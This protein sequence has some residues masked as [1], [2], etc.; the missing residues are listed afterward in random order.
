[1]PTAHLGSFANLLISNRSSLSFLKLGIEGAIAQNSQQDDPSTE[2]FIHSYTQDLGSTLD[3][4][5]RPISSTTST[6]ESILNDGSAALLHTGYL[7][8]IGF[9]FSSSFGKRF[10][11]QLF[12]LDHL[13]HLVLESCPQSQALFD[14][15]NC[16]DPERRPWHPKLKKLQLRFEQATSS[17]MTQ[18]KRFLFRFTGLESLQVLLE[19][20]VN[21]IESGCIIHHGHSLRTLVWDHRTRPVQ[22][23]NEQSHD[24]S[25]SHQTLFLQG[26]CDGC[27]ELR[28][29]GVVISCSSRSGEY[30]VSIYYDTNWL[31]LRSARASTIL[32]NWKIWHCWMCGT[33]L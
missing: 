10:K 29:L 14:L 19:G 23:D 5:V 32:E 25:P 9:R 3:T 20:D 7:H 8:L 17:L 28:E 21:P 22:E 12:D 13:V 18:L 33:C 6:G 2:N 16:D 31:E 24:Y 4:A 27:P 1:M 30:Q 26:I 15:A 11:Y